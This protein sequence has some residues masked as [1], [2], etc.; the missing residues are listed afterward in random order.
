MPSSAA[1]AAPQ[2]LFL[3]VAISAVAGLLL[4]GMLLPIVGGVGLLARTGANQFES[5]PAELDI[6]APPQVSRILAA[7]GSTI[8]TFYFQNRIEVPLSAVPAIMQKAIIAVEDVR[9]YEHH[10]VDFKGA[11][12]ALIHNGSAGTVRQG[13]STLTQQYVKNVL[14]EDAQQNNDAKAL[15]AA[16]A[17]TVSRKLKEARYALAL[18]K[19]YTKAQILEGYLNIAYFGDGAYG[20]GT[21]ARHYFNV[22]VQRLSLPQ[23]AMLAGLVQSPEAYDPAQHPQA[24]R[25][26]RDT[27]LSQMLKYHFISGADYD[28]AVAQPVKLHLHQQGNGCETSSAPYFCDYVQHVIERSP[29]FGRT[30]SERI[31]LLLRGGLTIRTT[32]QPKVQH[33]ADSAMHKYVFPRDP[34]GVAGAEA[35]V[36]PGTGKVL[37]LS[38]SRPYG[39]DAKR[40]QNTLNYAVDRAFGGGAT[41]FPGG[42]TFKLFVLAAAMKQGIPL[43]TRINAPQSIHLSGFT[44]CNGNDAGTWDVHNAGDSEA[45]T[46]DLNNGTW[47]SVNTFFAQLEQ[48]TGLCAPVKLAEAMGVRQE[49]GD[50]PVPYPSF[51]LGANPYGYSAL[52][53]AG[54]YATMAAHGEY[55]APIAITRVTDRSGHTF[56][57]QQQQCSQAV[58]PGLADTVTNI[59]HGVLTKPG[60]TAYNVGEPGRPAAA[61]TGT[62]ENSTASD[63]AG[64]VPQMAAAVWV[65]DPKRSTTRS[66]NG[67]NI[68]GRYYGQVFGA[69]IAG[70]IWRDT[71]EAALKG[72]PVE[73]LPPPD[74]RFVN[75]LTKAVPD[76]SGLLP[77]DALDV[78]KAA[79]FRGTVS[80][81]SV[82]SL[83]PKGTVAYTSP[84]GGGKAPPGSVITIY[85]SNGTAPKPSPTPTPSGKSKPPKGLSPSPTPSTSTSCTPKPHGPKHC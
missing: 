60:A 19:K 49:N 17:D 22:P 55:C 18:E 82:P 62:A 34:S 73:Q 27:V 61:K 79:G 66:L 57:A 68:G 42:S 3:L 51:T 44:D 2:R 6:G 77:K 70:P 78:L 24:A 36:E 52:D 63:F 71:M 25:D 83:F 4:A 15:A 33:A 45:G 39:Q 69:T 53:I 43:A 58:D 48:R 32:L 28:A 46:F 37:A 76:V 23:A 65:G 29:A 20:V 72:V 7:D 16:H 38:V 47:Y 50:A 26:R 35:V 41:G 12:R 56:K 85:L 30:R 1:A 5:L 40:G 81:T 11:L 13:G 74:P 8:A 64:Y 67:L 84:P 10:G 80:A 21:A 75:G 59:L 14:I 9:F 54:A 31:K